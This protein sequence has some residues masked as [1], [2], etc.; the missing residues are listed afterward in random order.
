MTR[1]TAHWVYDDHGSGSNRDVMVWGNDA[2]AHG[3]GM[4]KSAEVNGYSSHDASQYG[5]QMYCLKVCAPYFSP[6][7]PIP[8]FPPPA[9]Y[10]L[11]V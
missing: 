1:T 6:K 4:T 9:D 7:Y 3:F 10:F 2:C 8:A 11:P 5:V